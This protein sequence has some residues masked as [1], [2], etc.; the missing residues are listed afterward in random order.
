MPTTRC[1]AAPVPAELPPGRDRG[2]AWAADAYRH[3]AGLYRARAAELR[4]TAE[5][6]ARALEEQAEGMLARADQL[7]PLPVGRPRSG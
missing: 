6:E 5:A 2:Q 1:G 3:T 4:A 7:D